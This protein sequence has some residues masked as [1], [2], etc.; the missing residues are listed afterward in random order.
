MFELF[1][2]CYTYISQNDK[3]T[4]RDKK[5]R[6]KRKDIRRRKKMQT[7]LLFMSF[8]LIIYFCQLSPIMTIEC[9]QNVKP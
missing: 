8:E 7:N 5:H 9:A 1:F 2:E 4:K 3:Q 6:T